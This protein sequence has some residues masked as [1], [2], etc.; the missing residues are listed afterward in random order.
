MVKLKSECVQDKHD[1][2]CEKVKVVKFKKEKTI[3]V[4]KS[5]GPH[6]VKEQYLFQYIAYMLMMFY[7][8]IIFDLS[9]YSVVNIQIGVPQY[10]YYQLF[11]LLTF[12]RNLK[13]NWTNWKQSSDVN[14]RSVR[15]TLPV[16]ESPPLSSLNWLELNGDAQ[17]GLALQGNT[18]WGET[19]RIWRKW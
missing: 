12:W 4:D 8:L 2:K 18:N 7:S 17:A 10:A 14:Q 1:D 11:N 6:H 9:P 15:K 13:L 3:K 19:Q 16:V 5:W